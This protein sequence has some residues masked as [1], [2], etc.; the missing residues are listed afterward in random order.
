MSV[1]I[2]LMTDPKQCLLTCYAVSTTKWLPL[3]QEEYCPHLQHLAVQEEPYQKIWVYYIGNNDWGG[4]PGAVVVLCTEQSILCECHQVYTGQTSQSTET[5]VKQPLQHNHLGQADKSAMA[6]Q[7]FNMDIISNSRTPK[8]S[9]KS[10]SMNWIMWEA[11][12]IKQSWS[13]HPS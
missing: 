12:E 8:P 6:E 3:F 13:L 2:V 10:C 5:H 1:G 9:T 11:I 7:N 4:E